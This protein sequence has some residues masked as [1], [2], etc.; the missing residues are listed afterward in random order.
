[1]AEQVQDTTSRTFNLTLNPD[2]VA[3]PAHRAALICRE[4]I[5]LYFDA[6]SK[7]DLSQP[8]P[9]PDEAFFRF[10]IKGPNLSTEERRSAHERWVLVK[11]FQDLMRGVRGSLEEAYFF[12]ELLRM[13]RLRARTNSTLD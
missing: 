13:G 9:A 1:M 11:A 8:P 7:V 6:L 10:D 4:V 5:D 3:A 2:G 12:V